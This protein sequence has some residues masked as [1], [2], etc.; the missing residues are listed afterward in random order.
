[1]VLA[2]SKMVKYV[3]SPSCSAFE[4]TYQTALL[5]NKQLVD[6]VHVGKNIL[7]FASKYSFWA[8]VILFCSFAFSVVREGK[9]EE[10]IPVPRFQNTRRPFRYS[11]LVV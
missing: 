10:E 6:Y 8:K 2:A 7:R 1:M 5:Q 3:I 11:F 4:A 9:R